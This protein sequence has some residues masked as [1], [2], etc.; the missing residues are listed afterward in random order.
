MTDRGQ[1]DHI[2]D[3][4]AQI[5]STGSANAYVIATA[6]A[7]TGYARGM[8]PIRFKANFGNTG[9]ATANI[10]GLGAVTL[11][12]TGGTANL[13][14]GDIASSGVYTLVYDGANFQV[15]ELNSLPG[16][17]G[18]NGA[19]GANGVAA[20]LRWNFDSSTSMADPGTGD[21]RLNN[22]TLASVTAAAVSDLTGETGNP[23]AS[24]WV[25]SW[26]DSTNAVRGTLIVKK[27]GAEQNFAIYNITGASTDNSGWTQLVLTHVT[28]NGSLSNADPCVLNFVRAGNS[29]GGTVAV[30][31]FTSSGT[32]TPTAGMVSAIVEA[33][34]AGGGGG[35]GDSN[36]VTQ[37]LGAG[38][39]G[40]EYRRG[41]F[42]AATIGASQSVTIGAVGAAGST[43][44][45]N[46]GNASATSLG[47]L[48]SANG[49]SGG[50]GSGSN[51][52][53]STGNY[54]GGAGGSGGSGGH[55]A[56]SG[57][58]GTYGMGRSSGAANWGGGGGDSFLGHGADD[59]LTDQ[60]LTG[61]T[62]GNYGGGGSGGS[63]DDTSGSA[64]G[65]GGPGI[66]IVTEFIA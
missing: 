63:D 43:T 46:G 9:S 54:A 51:S 30:Q 41:V 21:F 18:A 28:S 4:S 32:Y 5:D 23:D 47:A 58:S 35:G 62:G 44:G 59:K 39:G 27:I 65:A 45:G 37:Q 60:D 42:S 2:W 8:P 12:K 13:A 19:D 31:V 64:G 17:A 20:G 29:G 53:N 57:K 36:G 1:T 11:K 56:I 14:S 6:Q 61:V 52:T 26:D 7:I 40:G 55:L 38:G 10:N 25:L 3:T 24:A 16:A 22:A 66:V 50:I 49:G 33:Q 34:A 48:I 15:L